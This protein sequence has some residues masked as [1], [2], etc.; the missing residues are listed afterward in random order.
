MK[1]RAR[2]DK[3]TDATNRLVSILLILKSM[4]LFARS[5]NCKTTA[6]MKSQW[7]V[8]ENVNFPE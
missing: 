5:I 7:L 3:N 4:V 1:K 6:P 8:L 2:I